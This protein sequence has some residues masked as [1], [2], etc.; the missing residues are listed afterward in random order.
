LSKKQCEKN[1]EKIDRSALYLELS[2]LRQTIEMKSLNNQPYS[3]EDSRALEIMRILGESDPKLINLNPYSRCT[4]AS[5]G[6][7][8]RKKKKISKSRRK[9]K[10]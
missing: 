8:F 2:R 5:Y 4:P 10:R 9:K 3:E 7:E 6:F 1:L